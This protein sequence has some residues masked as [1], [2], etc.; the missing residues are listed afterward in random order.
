MKE[1]LGAL[2][3]VLL[4]ILMWSAGAMFAAVWMWLFGFHLTSFQAKLLVI[5]FGV[6]GL[7]FGLVQVARGRVHGDGGE[8]GGSN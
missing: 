7:V 4:A 6:L 8:Q 1:K 5:V 2:R 3:F